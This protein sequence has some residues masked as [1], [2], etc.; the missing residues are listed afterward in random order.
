MHDQMSLPGLDAMPTLFQPEVLHGN[1]GK[2][3]GY[4]L[5]LAIV[6]LPAEAQRFSLIGGELRRR[7]GLTH[8]CLRTEHLHMTLHALAGY[9]DT[10]PQA[11]IDAAKAAAASVVC[12]PLPVVFDSALSFINHGQPDNN[13]YVLRCDAHSDAGVT[14]LRQAL[15]LALRRVGLLHAKPTSTPHMT[16]LYD[17]RVVAAHAIEP[18]RWTATRFTLILSHQGLTHH[19]WIGEWPFA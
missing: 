11:D 3:L 15:G 9:A 10:I 16:V 13:A 18:L 5:F 7:H 14:K 2:L 19:E 8:P 4:N 1:P 17:R 6:P 12:P